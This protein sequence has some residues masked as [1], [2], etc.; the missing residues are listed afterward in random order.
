MREQRGRRVAG[1]GERRAGGGGRGP[2][3]L[4]ERRAAHLHAKV[5]TYS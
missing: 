4:P 5:S 2:R 1:E 3:A